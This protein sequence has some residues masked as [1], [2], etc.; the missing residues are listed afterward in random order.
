MG[1]QKERHLL[2]KQTAQALKA[3]V[4]LVS[5]ILAASTTC[6][7]SRL[8]TSSGKMVLFPECSSRWI[9]SNS[10]MRS[11]H[12]PLPGSCTDRGVVDFSFVRKIYCTK[13]LD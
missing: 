2:L 13:L 10:L 12:G 1:H 8:G 4:R 11:R 6:Q 9:R 5:T 3:D 7:G